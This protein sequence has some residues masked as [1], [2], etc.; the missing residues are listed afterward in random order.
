MV[1]H[2]AAAYSAVAKP[3]ATKAGS[4]GV[5]CSAEA[6]PL[7]AKVESLRNPAKPRTPSCLPSRS[8]AKAGPAILSFIAAS[9]TEEAPWK[10]R[11]ILPVAAYSAA[12]KLLAA[13]AG[14]HMALP[15]PP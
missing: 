15:T 12:T 5:T 8:L 1:K 13:K 10:R 7:A 6:K 2:P 9:A 4:R 11:R 3:L 14:S